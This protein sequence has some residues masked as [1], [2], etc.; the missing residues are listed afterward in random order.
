MEDKG[1]VPMMNGYDE[2]SHLPISEDEEKILALYDRLQELRLEIAVINAQQSQQSDN[3]TS[4]TD[5][6][7]QKAQSEL[8]ETRAQYILRNDVTEAVVTANPILKA[9]HS[10]AET[11][12]I[13]RALLPYIERRDNASI[14]VATQ[15]SQTNTVWKALTTVQSDTLR[16]SR[17]NVT[18][19]AEL[20]ELADQAKLKK[21]VNPNNSKM[22]EGQERLEADVKASKQR[23]RVMKG[24]AGGIIVGSGVDWVQDDELRDAVLDPETEE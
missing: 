8:L 22:M 15:A 9:V 12:P 4:F 6:E 16:K 18:L 3:T 24:V 14:S 7:T 17:Q 10:N 11:A 2:T 13:E 21:R 20:F 23:W 19:A 1:D 5:E